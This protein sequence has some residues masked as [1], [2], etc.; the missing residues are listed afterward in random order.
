MPVAEKV[1]SVS[2]LIYTIKH[3]LEKSIASVVVSGEISNLSASAAGHYYFSL[4]DEESLIQAVLFKMDALRNPIIRHKSMKDGVKVCCSGELMIYPKRGSLQLLVR[5]LQLA[6]AGDLQLRFEALKKKL[7]LEG[8]FDLERKRAI[9]LFPKR[10]ALITAKGGAALQDFLS[11]FRRRSMAMNLLIVP[12]LVQG[13]DAPASLVEA[14]RRV[15]SQKSS[16]GVDVVVLARGGGSMEDLWAFN[17]ETLAREIYASTIPV[18]SAVGHQVDFTIADYVA[19]FRA[20]TPSAAAEFLSEGQMKLAMK[21]KHLREMLYVK[22][23]QLEQW[24][25]HTK[26]ISS[27]GGLAELLWKKLLS[28]QERLSRLRLNEAFAYRKLLLYEHRYA[29]EDFM[30]RGEH[31]MEGVLRERGFTLEKCYQTLTALD[32]KN[33]LKKGYAYIS[34]ENSIAITDYQKYAAVENG[35]RVTIHFSD[36]K[37]TAVK[38]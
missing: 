20:E 37:G 31:A 2:E 18:I 22:G 23:V 24:L 13:A 14:L 11:I 25:A 28:E 4:S 10:V 27:P 19:D 16:S 12:A 32:P 21:L 36:G 34:D 3:V 30:Q 7:Q 33:V 5:K 38:L 6:G 15:N 9:P 17:D 29:I 1:Y 35:Q 8:L 26:A